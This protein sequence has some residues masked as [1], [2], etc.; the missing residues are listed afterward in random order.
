MNHRNYIGPRC[1]HLNILAERCISQTLGDLD[2]T[3]VQSHVVSYLI[4]TRENPPCQRDLETF[5]SLSHPTVSGILSRLEE[6]GYITF[7]PD[8]SDRRRK[9]IAATEKAKVCAEHTKGV[10]E[11]IEEQM[12]TGFSP[13]ERAVFTDFLNRAI[14]NLGCEQTPGKE[15]TEK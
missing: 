12:L 9:R 3:P 14:K 15:N 6:K 8:P 4:C 1:K 5:F 2:L 7:E 13:E 10:L 11:E